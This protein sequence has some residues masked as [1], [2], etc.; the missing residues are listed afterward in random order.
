MSEGKR[1]EEIRARMVKSRVLLLEVPQEHRAGLGGVEKLE[2][3][4]PTMRESADAFERTGFATL[5]ITL[6]A[7]VWLPAVSGAAAE[8]LWPSPADLGEACHDNFTAINWLYSQALAFLQ[9]GK[10]A[11]PK[12]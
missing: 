11:S 7:M 2:L 9:E 5:A 8:R 4:A 1:S 12:G 10:A 6:S 3:R